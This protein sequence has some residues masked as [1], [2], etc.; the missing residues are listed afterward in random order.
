MQDMQPDSLLDPSLDWFPAVAN[1]A[2]CYELV[3][4][5]NRAGTG[6]HF[7]HAVWDFCSAEVAESFGFCYG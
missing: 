3:S 5:G 4:Q 7:E 6:G 2:W 1:A